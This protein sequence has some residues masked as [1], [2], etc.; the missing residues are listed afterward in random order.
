VSDPSRA[1][2]RRAER[3]L[4]CYPAG[5]RSRYGEEFRE[6]LIADICERP[7]SWV[8]TADVVRGGALARLTGTGLRGQALEHEQQLRASL[9]WL[10]AALAVFL[11]LGIAI[12]SQLTVG[13][14]W[15]APAAPAT[16]VAMIVMSGAILGFVVLALLATI[17]MAWALSVALPRRQ[18]LTAPLMLT[19]AGAT[20]LIAG[21]LHFGHGW[22]GTGGHPWPDRGLVPGGVARFCW[23]ATLW[24]TT[25]WVHPRALFSFPA[26]E[27]GWMAA[28]PAALLAILVGAGKTLR[29][30]QLSTRVL[31]YEA[32]LGTAATAA[33]ASFLAGAGCWIVSG[34]PAPRG[35]FRVGAID[36]VGLAAMTVALVLAFRAVQRALTASPGLR[37]TRYPPRP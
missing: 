6:L 13:W 12:W 3:L 5:W 18:G 30:A 14:Q 20:A 23:A 16:T 21:S 28:S 36:G 31:R 7:R 8:R 34:G 4:R 24:V 32:W 9:A 17:P 27:I 33:M 29:R 25:Y 2:A 35:L 15:S 22:P 10:G 26:A 37:T 1:A 11:A 19:I